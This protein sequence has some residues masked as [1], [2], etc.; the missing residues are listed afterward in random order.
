MPVLPTSTPARSSSGGG[1]VNSSSLV[2]INGPGA[3]V[4]PAS[5]A[6]TAPITLA[7][8]T[9]DGSGGT[10]GNVTVLDGTGGTV[11]NGNGGTG[12]LTIANLTF[13]GAAAVT[14]NDSG[15]PMT[16]G[17]IVSGASTT[18]A[19]DTSGTV[20][21]DASAVSWSSSATY[22]LIQYGSLRGHGVGRFHR[23]DDRRAHR[24]ADAKLDTPTVTSR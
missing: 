2:S 5:L 24:A 15:A 7:Q 10:V 19:I 3:V 12:T 9:L 22:D 1:G 20:T 6:G 17:L 21:I 16:P 13:N 18:G 11:T 4:R 8:G 14:V 23:G